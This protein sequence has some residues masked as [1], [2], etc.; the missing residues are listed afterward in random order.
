[1]DR[2]DSLVVALVPVWVLLT[3][4]RLIE[5]VRPAN[6]CERRAP[7]TIERR[8]SVSANALARVSRAADSRGTSAPYPPP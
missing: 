6:A 5:P 2:L 3:A 7:V 4:V 1:M 8:P